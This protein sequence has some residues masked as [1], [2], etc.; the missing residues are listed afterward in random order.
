MQGPLPHAANFTCGVLVQL[1]PSVA[2]GL[3]ANSQ[4]A[5]LQYSTSHLAAPCWKK[6]SGRNFTFGESQAYALSA[7]L[8]IGVN[9]GP[10]GWVCTRLDSR[11]AWFFSRAYSRDARPHSA[12]SAILRSTARDPSL[13]FCFRA[14][15][16]PTKRRTTRTGGL[17][18][19]PSDVRRFHIP[20]SQAPPP[21]P[22]VRCVG[23]RGAPCGG[24]LPLRNC[25]R[26]GGSTS[27]AAP[28][29]CQPAS[30]ASPTQHHCWFGAATLQHATTVSL[31]R[32]LAKLARLK[33]QDVAA[34]AAAACSAGGP[35]SVGLVGGIG[36]ICGC[37][38]QR[39]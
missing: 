1:Q 36:R 11:F 23:L 4:S 32:Y 3:P 29:A 2:L 20:S 9:S 6:L 21:A 22:S 31:S 24:P 25:C 15:L 33:E 16:Q 34:A 19:L 5:V 18:F 14:R 10:G 12:K 35:L 13:S 7:D 27:T 38:T 30:P 17:R 28:P 37:A 26:Y 8:S 39:K